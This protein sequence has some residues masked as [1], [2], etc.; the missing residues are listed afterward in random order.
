M[1]MV[2]PKKIVQSRVDET[3][4]L[5][6]CKVPTKNKP[7]FNPKLRE[8]SRKKKAIFKKEGRSDLYKSVV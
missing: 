1:S 7:W 6:T 2:A 8:L 5:K 3:F 4:P